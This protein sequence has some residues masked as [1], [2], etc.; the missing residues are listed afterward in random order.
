MTAPDQIQITHRPRTMTMATIRA[1]QKA[2]PEG[3]GPTDE[4]LY[5]L[6]EQFNG[7]TVPAM[8]RALELWGNPLQGAPAPG[9]N[10]A[11]DYIDPEHTGQ[12]R[13]L[14]EVFYRACNSEGGTADEIHLRGIKAVLAA[15][16]AAPAAQAG[17]VG[18]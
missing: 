14:L 17:D 5:D 8:R 16:R 3:E 7:D 2:E 18:P 1:A 4:D 9:E 10:L 6:A 12:D 11:T 13:E 15:L